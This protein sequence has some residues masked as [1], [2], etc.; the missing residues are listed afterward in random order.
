MIVVNLYFYL[1][2]IDRFDVGSIVGVWIMVF[3]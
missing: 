2:N 1:V 3:G